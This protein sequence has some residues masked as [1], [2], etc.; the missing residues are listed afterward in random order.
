LA[1]HRIN[2]IDVKIFI[3]VESANH[4]NL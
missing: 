4:V 1:R 2:T 3:S